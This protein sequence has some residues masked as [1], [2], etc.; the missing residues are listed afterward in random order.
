MITES[1]VLKALSVPVPTLALYHEPP[2]IVVPVLCLSLQGVFFS[3]FACVG[4]G[5]VID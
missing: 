1:C 3:D 4:A 2:C 5:D